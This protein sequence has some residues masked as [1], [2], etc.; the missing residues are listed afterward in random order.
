MLYQV[1]AN[2]A[3]ADC[4]I[5]AAAVSD[6]RPKRVLRKKI[7]KIDDIT[8]IKLTKNS[9]ILKSIKGKK[10]NRVFTGFALETDNV[11]KNA[12]KK[13]MD[14]ELD[15][16]VANELRAKK[17]AFGKVKNTYY[18]IDKSFNTNI[19]KNVSKKRLSGCLIDKSIKL[20][21][22]NNR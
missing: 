8:E 14:K 7:K 3:W 16:I 2:L 17:N 11:F 13:L 18:I 9:D 19:L 10:E 6:F 1:R 21:Y 4:L 22:T 5:M 15:L 12:K 20:W